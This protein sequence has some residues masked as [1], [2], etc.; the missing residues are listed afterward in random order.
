MRTVPRFGR[1]DAISDAFSGFRK[2]LH[3]DTN[4]DQTFSLICNVRRQF[5]LSP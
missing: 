5:P 3:V 1:T 4:A 2:P